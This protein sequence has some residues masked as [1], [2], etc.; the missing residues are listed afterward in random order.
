M[1]KSSLY[2]KFI[3]ISIAAIMILSALTIVIIANHVLATC[4]IVVLAIISIAGLIL[5]FTLITKLST[6]LTNEIAKSSKYS[7]ITPDVVRDIGRAC[8]KLDKYNVSYNI[9]LE[10]GRVLAHVTMGLYTRMSVSNNLD[11]LVSYHIIGT[12]TVL[13]KSSETQ[14]NEYQCT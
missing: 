3:N 10:T 11:S 7:K 5:S 1:I 13:L 2:P 4:I 14:N 12:D 8:V 9:D 6:S